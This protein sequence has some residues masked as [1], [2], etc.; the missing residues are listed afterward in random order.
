MAEAGGHLRSLRALVFSSVF[1]TGCQLQSTKPDVEPVVCECP[2]LV[3]VAP[4]EPQDCPPAAANP[5][6]PV[7]AVNDVSVETTSPLQQRDD[8]LIVGRV[9][10]VTLQPEH[11][12]VKARVDTGAGLTS[13]NALDLLRFERDG[14]AWV[15]FAVLEPKTDNKIILERKI[16]RHISIKQLSGN[17]QRRPVVSMGL[18]LGSIE[19]QVD[20]TLTDRSAYVY[21]LLIGRN[22]L[23]DRALVDVSQK[24]IARK[25]GQ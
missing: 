20:I 14:K 25:S 10:Y 11:L 12:A 22:F 17:N 8:K 2:E 19:E 15:R 5:V 13:L 7:P 23:R 1:L 21:Q 3:A 16:K 24:F 6:T 4:L 9:E 18:Q